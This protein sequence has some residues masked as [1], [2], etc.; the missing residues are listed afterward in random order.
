M[1]Y[2]LIDVSNLVHRA[3]HA[4]SKRV[5]TGSV[6]DP[7]GVMVSDEDE[8]RTGLIM[9]VIFGGIIT[10]YMR[11]GGNHCVPPLTLGHGVGMSKSPTRPIVVT[12]C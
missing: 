2:I 7:F 10:S 9:D 1:K 4:V 5:V 6:F 11:F 3:K 8:L 12:G